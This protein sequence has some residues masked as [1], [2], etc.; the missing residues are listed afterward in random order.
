MILC[1]KFVSSYQN[2]LEINSEKNSIDQTSIN[3]KEGK[4]EYISDE[5]YVNKQKEDIKA[6]AGFFKNK[7]E[8]SSG[9]SVIEG[10]INAFKDNFNPKPGA[11]VGYKIV[12]TDSNKTLAIKIDGPSVEVKEGDV[13]YPGCTLSMSLDILGAITSGRKTF[14]GGF[15]DGSIVAK[16]DFK[17]LRTLDEI[18]PF[19]EDKS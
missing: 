10:Y 12:F 3:L 19:M 9:G 17:N 4:P 15:M 1:I 2:S 7:L 18:F 5:K 11:Q 6:L 14:Q 16:G 13:A 8:S